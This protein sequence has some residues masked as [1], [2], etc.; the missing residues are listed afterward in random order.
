MKFSI[1][2]NQYQEN[3]IKLRKDLNQALEKGHID[4]EFKEKLL[5]VE[6]TENKMLKELL[7][8][9]RLYAPDLY[10]TKF[11]ESLLKP[12]GGYKL[13]TYLKSYLCI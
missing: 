12:A 10:E 13:N 8:Y 2:I 5:E 9:Y 3:L 6:E 4:K 7:P 11:E 1:N